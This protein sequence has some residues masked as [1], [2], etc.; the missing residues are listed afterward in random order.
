MK[1]QRQHIAGLELP[2]QLPVFVHQQALVGIRHPAAQLPVFGGLL[3]LSQQLTDAAE[4]GGGIAQ[5]CRGRPLGALL[6]LGHFRHIRGHPVAEMEHGRSM[7]DVSLLAKA[8]E[9]GPEFAGLDIPLHGIISFFQHM[10]VAGGHIHRPGNQNAGIVPEIHRHIGHGG[11]EPV[12][13][14]RDGIGNASGPELLG[15]QIP[16][17]F[18]EEPGHIEIKHGSGGENGDVP[19]PAH[20]FVP[21]GTVR[22]NLHEVRPGAPPDVFIQSVQ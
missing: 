15:T 14:G 19:R 7:P 4:H 9:L 8:K 22:G 18:P 11:G 2:G 13:L 1:I 20:P 17:P 21:L 5:A 10:D 12:A 6:P 3:L 16:Q